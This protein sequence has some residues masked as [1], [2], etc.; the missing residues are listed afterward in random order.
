MPIPIDISASTGA[1]ILDVSKYQTKR[2]AWINLMER[3]FPGFCK[4]RG[5]KLPEPPDN[6]AIRL[7]KDFEFAI[8]LLAEKIEGKKIINVDK[9]YRH[10][11]YSFITCH[12]DGNIKNT[13]KHFESKTSNI[14]VYNKDWGKPETDKV[15]KDIAVQCQHQ[16]ICTGKKFVHVYLLVFPNHQDQWEEAEHTLDPFKIQVWA[17]TLAEMGYLK[18]YIIEENKTLQEKMISRYVKFWQNNVLK[19][20]MPD[21]KNLDDISCLLNWP[22]GRLVVGE[23]ME[24][25]HNEYKNINAETN[26]A[27]KHKEEIKFHFLKFAE[28]KKKKITEDGEETLIFTSESGEDLFTWNGKTFRLCGRNLDD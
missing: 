28:K 13:Q 9:L 5:L 10:K 19:A 4:A 22:P 20:K 11:K 26:R 23:L 15:P 8:K 14:F 16:L 27:Q 2:Q 6:I 12:V 17:E 21:S 7:G 25:W 18:R 1:A 24:S 3:K